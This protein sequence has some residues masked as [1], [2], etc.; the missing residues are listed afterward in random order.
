MWTSFL[1]QNFPFFFFFGIQGYDKRERNNPSW[2]KS[3]R[4]RQGNK[5]D[6]DTDKNGDL[7]EEDIGV[8]TPYKQ[9]VRKIKEALENLDMPPMKVGTIEHFQG[10][11]RPDIDQ[12]LNTMTFD[13]NHC[14]GFF[15][16]PR[17][18]NVAV[19]RSKQLLII[20]QGMAFLLTDFQQYSWNACFLVGASPSPN[21]I[22][23]TTGS[24]IDIFVNQFPP[25]L[26]TSPE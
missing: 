10:Q 6:K 16:N 11:E 1:T 4:G 22:L 8:I 23:C 9:Q 24:R 13:R 18:F 12:Q 2:F 20:V 14:L 17:R 15:S 25:N 3:V 19:T 26:P 7:C 21:F 5:Y